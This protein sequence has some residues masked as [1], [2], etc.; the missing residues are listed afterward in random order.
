[1]RTFLVNFV[2]NSAGQYNAD[3]VL[4]THETFPTSHEIYQHIKS[5]A[6]EKG[7]QLH[8]SILWTG[9]TELN[10]GDEQQFNREED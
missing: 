7:L 3:F 1:M 9:I 5:T 4:F 2:Y 10:K 6:V 8:G